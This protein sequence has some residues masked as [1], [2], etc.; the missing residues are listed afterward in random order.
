MQQIH[1]IDLLS[2]DAQSVAEVYVGLE[3]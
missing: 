3:P 1:D 2:L